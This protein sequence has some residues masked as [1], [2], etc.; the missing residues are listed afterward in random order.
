MELVRHGTILEIRLFRLPVP[1]SSHS[2]SVAIRK[3]R[4]YLPRLRAPFTCGSAVHSSELCAALCVRT[5]AVG[6]SSASEEG[7]EMSCM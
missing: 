2:S 5:G 1:I 6:A 7:T 4:G 3:L